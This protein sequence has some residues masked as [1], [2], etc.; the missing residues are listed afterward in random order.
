MTV[1]ANRLFPPGYRRG[2]GEEI[3]MP[4]F[5]TRVGGVAIFFAPYGD[6]MAIT[7]GCKLFQCARRSLGAGKT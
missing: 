7:K 2:V 6:H 4:K 5:A 1:L 3:T